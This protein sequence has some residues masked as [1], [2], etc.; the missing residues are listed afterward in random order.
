MNNGQQ[1][2]GD[3]KGA[4]TF[5]NWLSQCV[6]ARGR[7]MPVIIQVITGTCVLC[8]VLYVLVDTLSVV[9]VPCMMLRVMHDMMMM[10]DA[11]VPVMNRFSSACTRGKYRCG[12]GER[13]GKAES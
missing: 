13:Y 9:L 8:S 7:R 5:E 1:W 11:V 3:Q 10:V 12:D 2:G 4:I 6:K